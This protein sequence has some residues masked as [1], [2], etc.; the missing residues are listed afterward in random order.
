MDPG[1]V[2]GIVGG[3]LGLAGGVVGTYFSIRNTSGPREQAFM[4]RVS[5]IAWV[6]VTAFLAGLLLLP[7]PYN[8]FLWIP[9]GIALPLA[10]R[11]LNRHQQQIRAEEAASRDR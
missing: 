4:I 6:A 8:W 11:S 1:L 5:V 9:Y 7:K 3:G 10:I 2:G